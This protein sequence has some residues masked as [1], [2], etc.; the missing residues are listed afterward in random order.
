MPQIAWWELDEFIFLL[1]GT[2]YGIIVNKA[3][4]GAIAGFLLMKFYC[5]LK[6]RRQEGYLFHVLYTKGL[7]GLKGRVPE[8][9][10]KEYVE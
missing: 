6:N 4:I 10:I 7:Y 8:F 1:I 9:W 3:W 5:K 2:G